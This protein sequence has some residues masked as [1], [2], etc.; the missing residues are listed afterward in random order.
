MIAGVG[1]ASDGVAWARSSVRP[2]GADRSAARR[3]GRHRRAGVAVRC[4]C[5]DWR[6]TAHRAAAGVADDRAGCARLAAHQ[7]ARDDRRA[8]QPAHARGALA[9]QVALSVT[10]LVVTALLGVS[11]V[12]LMRVDRGFS[13]DH[14][15]AVDVSLPSSRYEREPVRV[16]VYDCILAA[17]QMLPGVM[18][19]SWTSVLP[20]KG[21]DW[22]DLVTVEGDVRPIFERPIAN[23][24]FVAPDFFRALEMPIRRGRAFADADRAPSLPTTPAVISEATAARAW[25]GQTRSGS[26]SGAATATRSRSKSSASLSTA[27]RR[28]RY[29]AAD[30]GVR[31]C[32]FRSRASAAGD[33]HE[34]GSAVIGR[35]RAAQH[36]ER[37]SEI[38]VGES[39]PL[40]RSSM[41]VRRAPVSGDAVCRLWRRGLLSRSSVSTPSPRTA[42]RAAGAR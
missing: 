42:C 30:D 2:H 3:R 39:R 21:Q 23:Y 26:A 19:A 24:R 16:A 6:R 28:A 32:W 34:R 33:P 35:R 27:V 9:L 22:A 25:P 1:G 5:L 31:P 12:K 40:E 38:A 8:R 7:R 15:L 10:L 36:P 14:V 17:L 11:F 20:L 13:A 29:G 37:R 18:S 4:G 41:P